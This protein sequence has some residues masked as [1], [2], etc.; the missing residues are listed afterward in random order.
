MSDWK[1]FR[2]SLASHP[3]LM[4]G[5]AWPLLVFFAIC[6]RSEMPPIGRALL[7]TAGFGMLPWIPILITAWTMRQQYRKEEN[8]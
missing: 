8:I 7:I 5:Y 6:R 4:I 2:L 3:G 1:L